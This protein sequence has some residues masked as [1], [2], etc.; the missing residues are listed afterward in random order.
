MDVLHNW[1]QKK[2]YKKNK[3]GWKV[4]TKKK[5]KIFQVGFNIS[6]TN[7]KSNAKDQLT[8]PSRRELGQ[9]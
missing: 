2:K 7:M 8:T 9:C 6:P 5:R 3:R 1:K 4:M